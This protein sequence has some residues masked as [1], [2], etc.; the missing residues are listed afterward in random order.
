[1]PTKPADSIPIKSPVQRT[2]ESRPA[3]ADVWAGIFCFPCAG[4]S[5]SLQQNFE[6]WKKLA[7]FESDMRRQAFA[8]TIQ[9]PGIVLSQGID[10]PAQLLMVCQGALGQRLCFCALQQ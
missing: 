7:L 10:Q 5:L 1:M 8:E 4:L 6:H 2:V 9:C 3:R